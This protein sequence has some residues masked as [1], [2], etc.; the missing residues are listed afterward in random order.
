MKGVHAAEDEAH[1]FDTRAAVSRLCLRPPARNRR[2]G[3]MA[4]V[5]FAGRPAF[6]SERRELMGGAPHRV[7]PRAP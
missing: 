2:V 4:R 6:T 3:G 7:Q 1:D 5:R